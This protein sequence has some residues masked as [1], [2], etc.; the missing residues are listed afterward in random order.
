[1]RQ[2]QWPIGLLLAFLGLALV[3]IGPAPM[4]AACGG[5]FCTTI[6][7]DQNAERI[8]FTENGDGTISA[9]IQIEYT[10]AA[11]DFSWILPLPTPITAD[12]IEVPEAGM[13]MFDELEVATN[14]RIIPPPFPECAERVL[15]AAVV[16]EADGGVEVFAAGEVGPFGFDVVGSEDPEALIDWLR[17]HNYRVTVDMEP[18]IDVYVAEEFVFLAMRLLPDKESTDIE[19]VKVTYRSNTPMIPLRLTA[20]AANPDMAVMV[21]F[22]GPSPVRPTNYA[23]M[24]IADEDI[25]FFD[26]GGHNY[27]QL[28]GQTADQF[29]GQAF[30]TEYARPTSALSFA[31]P[32]LQALTAKHRFLTRLNTVISPEEMTVDPEFTYDASLPEITNVRDL[33]QMRGLYRCERDEQGVISAVAELLG[34]EPAGSQPGAPGDGDGSRQVLVLGLILGAAVVLAAVVLGGGLVWLV[35]RGR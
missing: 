7:V 4:A 30:I 35:R 9:Y 19:P 2:R 14:V 28:M 20:V 10:G 22:F 29:N 16:E 27:R 12:D 18:L 21:W 32:E 24:E 6:P 31:H 34:A 15:A 23:H 1:M 17:Q 3:A 26:F 11:P 5:F 8:I 25:V 13:D 33:S